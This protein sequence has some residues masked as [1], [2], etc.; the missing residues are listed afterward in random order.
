MKLEWIKKFGSGFQGEFE[1][2]YSQIENSESI[3]SWLNDVLVSWWVILLSVGITLIL[4][5]IYMWFLRLFAKIITW[6]IIFSLVAAVAVS[7][8]FVLREGLNREDDNNA[9]ET[10]DESSEKIWTIRAFKYG[11]IGLMAFSVILLLFIFCICHRISLVIAVIEATSKFVADTMTVILVPIIDAIITII[12]VA[13]W[14]VGTVFIYSSGD[15]KKRDGLPFGEVQW[16]DVERYTFYANIFA[17]L[18]IVAFILSMTNFVIA[19]ACCIWYFNQGR[20]KKDRTD[21]SPVYTGYK[22]VFRYHFG[23]IAFGA[24]LLAFIWALKIIMS[25]LAKKLKDTKATENKFVRIL[26]K[27]VFCML[28]CFERFIR[29]I[30]KQAFIQVKKIFKTRLGSEDLISAELLLMGLL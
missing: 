25:Y 3:Q 4:A 16:N 9:L 1:R 23:S 12:F 6:T 13:F 14:V 7:G 28:D 10:P 27:V 19:A 5:F 30:N 29:F 24:F 15:L 26:L 21:G 18:W 20:D 22:W 11:G 2:Y 8:Y 17:V